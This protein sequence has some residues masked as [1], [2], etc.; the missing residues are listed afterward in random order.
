[1]ALTESIGPY[2]LMESTLLLLESVKDFKMDMKIENNTAIKY[3]YNIDNFIKAS[4]LSN[5][6]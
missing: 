1:M 6:S 2:T 3:D 5:R 4:P